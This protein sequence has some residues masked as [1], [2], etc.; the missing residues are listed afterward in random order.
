MDE[1]RGEDDD[2]EKNGGFHRAFDEVLPKRQG[3]EKPQR[4]KR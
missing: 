1:E 3:K 2:D 4:L